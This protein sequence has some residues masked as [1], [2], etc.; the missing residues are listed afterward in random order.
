MNARARETTTRGRVR[1]VRAGGGGGPVRR[2][3]K[4][5]RATG[6]WARATTRRSTKSV[7]ARARFRR[8]SRPRARQIGWASSG[9]DTVVVSTR[10]G[11]CVTHRRAGV[12]RSP[13][14][15]LAPP[16]ALHDR[17]P[18][19][20]R[21]AARSRSAPGA[22]APSARSIDALIITPPPPDHRRRRASST[23]GRPHRASTTP[24]AGTPRAPRC[25][26]SRSPPR[27]RWP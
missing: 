13:P 22:L 3:S 10:A 16:R 7:A 17:W 11:R 23:S 4:R 1:G 25:S 19:W 20:R 8:G 9:V 26:V 5:K 2:G 27:R 18:R 6:W 24:P 12:R 21:R 14:L 15:A